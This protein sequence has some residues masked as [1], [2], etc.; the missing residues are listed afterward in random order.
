MRRILEVPTGLY[1]NGAQKIA[2]DI[3]LLRDKQLYEIHYVVFEDTVDVYEKDLA[4]DGCRVIHLPLQ[5]KGLFS[6]FE[7]LSRLKRLMRQERYDAVHAHCA[8]KSGI[9]MLAAK[10]AGVPI[11]IVHSHNTGTNKSLFGGF[12]HCVMRRLIV[13]CA[14]DLIACG[15]AA[16]AYLFG[17]RAYE[18][19]GKLILNGADVEGF[20]FSESGRAE[21]REKLGL[22]DCFVIGIAA[23]LEPQ[24]NHRFLIDL[25]PEILKRRP[26]A[27]LLVI[28]N[29]SERA[30]LE[31]QAAALGLRD[32]ILMYGAVTDMKPYYNAMDVFALPS[33]FEGAPLA[34]MEA[35][36]N[37]LPCVISDN[38]PDDV[39]LTDLIHTVPLHDRDA[40][41]DTVC[42]LKRNEPL[43]YADKLRRLGMDYSDMMQK[44]YRLYK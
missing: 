10:T 3:G 27:V 12:F 38:V 25:L 44:I 22:Q 11:R 26:D 18:K 4:A 29:G 24:K 30:A 40:W 13:S 39:K 32:R 6:F 7:M 17:R 41:A 14:T 5:A 20:R 34:L 31:E 37:G 35:Q 42:G 43:R 9:V 16:G 21:I 28:G 2:Q 36:V 23:R 33:L 1:M 19:R 15:N 8:F